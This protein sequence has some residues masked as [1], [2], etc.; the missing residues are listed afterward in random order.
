MSFRDIYNTY[1]PLA[2]LNSFTHTYGSIY[3]VGVLICTGKVHCRSDRNPS[4]R[5]A[6]FDV[7][8]S[9]HWIH[10]LTPSTSCGVVHHGSL[11]PWILLSLGSIMRVLHVCCKPYVKHYPQKMERKK[12]FLIN[13]ILVV[14]LYLQ[15]KKK[16]STPSVKESVAMRFQ[17]VKLS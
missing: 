16:Y 4:D 5:H 10:G 6:L 1:C 9:P 17:L 13:K 12:L 14:L 15:I 8:L 11:L 2:L 7:L 3:F